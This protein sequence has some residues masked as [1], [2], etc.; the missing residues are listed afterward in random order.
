[1]PTDDRRRTAALNQDGDVEGKEHGMSGRLSGNPDWSRE[2]VWHRMYE[3]REN[4]EGSR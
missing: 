4:V 3:V 1:M 2:G